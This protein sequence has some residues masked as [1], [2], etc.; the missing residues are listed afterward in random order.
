MFRRSSKYAAIG[1]MAFMI[2]QGGRPLGAKSSGPLRFEKAV[3]SRITTESQ[4]QPAA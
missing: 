1:G 2:A 4:P 3:Q